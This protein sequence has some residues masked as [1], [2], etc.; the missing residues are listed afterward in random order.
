MKIECASDN[1][2]EEPKVGERERSGHAGQGA[3]Q[4]GAG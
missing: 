3:G 1:D 4:V 2:S